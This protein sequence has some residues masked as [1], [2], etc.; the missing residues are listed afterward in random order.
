MMASFGTDRYGPCSTTISITYSVVFMRAG[1]RSV[2]SRVAPEADDVTFV[3]RAWY[4]EDFELG[5]NARTRCPVF[6]R[7]ASAP[8]TAALR[9]LPEPS[10]TPAV[11]THVC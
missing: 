8:D 1:A 7:P 6:T 3:T 2:T 5:G 9:I 10:I 4:I 11:R